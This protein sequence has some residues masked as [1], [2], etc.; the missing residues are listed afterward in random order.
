MHVF[1]FFF[2]Y[3]PLLPLRWKGKKTRKTL[4]W[5]TGWCHGACS[6]LENSQGWMSE[7]MLLQSTNYTRILWEL[8]ELVSDHSHIKTTGSV[9]PSSHQYGNMSASSWPSV[10]KH[11]TV[12][13][14]DFKLIDLLEFLISLTRT[15]TFFGV[16]ISLKGL[17]PLLHF[18]TFFG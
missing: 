5:H 1:L 17:L 14:K 11:L 16:L 9:G 18:Y 8:I 2:L 3:P 15:Q 10:V 4:K 7:S 12:I 13:W 6:V